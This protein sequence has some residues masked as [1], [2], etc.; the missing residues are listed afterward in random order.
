M[1]VKTY[2]SK[3]LQEALDHIAPV[4]YA[5]RVAPVSRAGTVG[6]RLGLLAREP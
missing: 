6:L 5:V 2:Q 3:S 4:A 1:N